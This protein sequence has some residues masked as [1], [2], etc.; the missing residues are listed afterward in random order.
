[1]PMIR[2]EDPL[3]AAGFVLPLGDDMELLAMVTLFT[4]STAL[5]LAAARLM[6]S[7]VFYSM[8]RLSNRNR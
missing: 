7:A 3:R 8:A 6:L 4:L 1:M 2:I 5:A